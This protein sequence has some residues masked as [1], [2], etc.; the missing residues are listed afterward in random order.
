M[1]E[2]LELIT[3][4]E[5]LADGLHALGERQ[6]K[7]AHL[8]EAHGVLLQ[9][10][11]LP[12]PAEER[13][14]ERQSGGPFLDHGPRHARRAGVVKHGRADNG[15]V[16]RDLPRVVGDEQGPPRRHV[17]DTEDFGAEV[18]PVEHRDDHR[19][20]ARGVGIETEWIPAERDVALL[21]ALHALFEI[22]TQELEAQLVFGA[23]G[24]VRHPG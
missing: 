4:S 7:L 17:L 8:Q 15:G 9:A 23:R 10:D 6:H 3:L 11:Y 5:W 22:F 1:T 24:G 20:L 21:Q 16:D 13:R 14:N 19:R 12:Y 2:G 18:E